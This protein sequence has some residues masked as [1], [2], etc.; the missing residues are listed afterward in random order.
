MSDQF[1]AAASD[2]V[3]RAE[4]DAVR[5]ELEQAKGWTKFWRDKVNNQGNVES[6]LR[7]EL[8][9]AR[10]ERDELRDAEG[11]GR[12]STRDA[13]TSAQAP[14]LVEVAQR[15]QD[16]LERIAGGSVDCSHHHIARDALAG[17]SD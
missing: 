8:E 4:L 6:D 1:P 10:K 5:A 7:A 17:G 12:T 14:L 2:W 11:G 9:Q 16:A 13:G 3:S 15:Y